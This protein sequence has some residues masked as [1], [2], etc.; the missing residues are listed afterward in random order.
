[1]LRERKPPPS[2]R[3]Q[4]KWSG[5]RLR[6]FGLIR[7]R[8]RMS[9]GSLPSGFIT[10]RRQIFRRMSW[11]SAGDCMRNANKTPK[12]LYYAFV[13]EVEKWSVSRTGLPPD[14]VS[15]SD[16]Y[17]PNH[18]TKLQWNRLITF[19]AI[20]HIDRQTEWQANRT[21]RVTSASA[22]VTI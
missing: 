4:P 5:I 17:R 2:P 14:V 7:I 12:I 19:A 6:I 8:I 21:D 9:S 3:S 10:Y 1:M 11:K 13:R 22:K 15:S 18:N 16:W 20:L